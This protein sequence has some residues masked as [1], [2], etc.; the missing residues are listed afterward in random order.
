MHGA[1]CTEIHLGVRR[2][3]RR[4]AFHKGNPMARLSPTQNLATLV[5]ENARAVAANLHAGGADL[6]V[7][8]GDLEHAALEFSETSES[9]QGFASRDTDSASNLSEDEV[10]TTIAQQLEV[11]EVLIAAGVAT[12]EVEATGGTEAL[13]ASVQRL[14]ESLAAEGLDGPTQA[15]FAAS[16]GPGDRDLDAVDLARSANDAI[17]A[18]VAGVL[19]VLQES[20]SRLCELPSLVVGKIVNEVADLIEDVPQVGRLVRLGLQAIKQALTAIAEFVPQALRDRAK[21]WARKWWTERGDS[22]QTQVVSQLLS[23]PKAHAA[24]EIIQTTSLDGQ[25]MDHATR[26]IADLASRFG[27]LVDTFRRIIRAIAA[28][29]GVAALLT[30]LAVVSAWVPVAAASGYVLLAGSVLLIARD[31]LDSGGIVCRVDGIQ[32]IL[33]SVV[34]A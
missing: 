15:G 22:A 8:I 14:E 18:V 31:Y 16:T 21:E 32:R 2:R 12:D 9:V 1:Q 5:A 17:D 23:A 7:A 25:R 29:A 30:S 13:L 20:W 3:F 4:L 19:T 24:A 27:R 28:A 33:A 11:A 6:R 10:L 34:S 26:L